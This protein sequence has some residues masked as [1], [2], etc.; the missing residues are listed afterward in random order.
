M[1][2]KF[3]AA[4]PLAFSLAACS[5]LAGPPA[6]AQD[7]VTPAADVDAL[8]TDPDPKLNANKQAAW[9]IMKDLLE[10]GHW[11]LAD[12]WMTERYIQHNPNV[13]SGRQT[14]VDFFN[15]LGIEPK[16]IPEHLSTPVVQVVAE[17]DYVVVVSA[18][19][20]PVPGDPDKTYTTSWFDMWRFVDGKADEHWDNA[21]MTPK[22]E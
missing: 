2:R 15:G 5:T 10:A 18:S 19:Q 8:F 3:I 4:L 16:P 14:V 17:G 12:K 13:A 20:Q 11:E 1:T 9:H 22:P 21:T 7:A 6:V